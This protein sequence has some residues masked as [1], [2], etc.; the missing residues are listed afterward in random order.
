MLFLLLAL[1]PSVASLNNGQ[2]NALILG[3]I[4]LA[5]DAVCEERWQRVAFCIALAGAF[6]VYPLMLGVVLIA[7]YPRQL[8][9][10][11]TLW[12]LVALALPFV[13]QQPEYVL[14]QYRSWF[15]EVRH[16]DRQVLPLALAYRD[17]RLMLRTCGMPISQSAYLGIQM[18]AAGA[19]AGFA[20][21]RRTKQVSDLGLLFT[22]SL[23][24]MTALGP[25]TEACTYIL[26]AP[27]LA[28]AAV[29]ARQQRWPPTRCV[30]LAIAYFL[31]TYPQLPF[32]LPGAGMLANHA[33]QCV[34]ALLLATAVLYTHLRSDPRNAI[35]R[36][37]MFRS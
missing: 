8:G 18:L 4:L 27:V 37:S 28:F 36:R 11:L 23:L 19:L 25:A 15:A 12:G 21:T 32:R 14:Q 5:M 20:A 16:D 17:L 13:L 29:Q 33:A 31:V 34:G 10:R 22:L 26:L 9:P 30:I 2:A 7:R 6:K 35:A 1:P 3:L 24:W